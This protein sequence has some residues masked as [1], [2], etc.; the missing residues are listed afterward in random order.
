MPQ[1][2]HTLAPWGRGEMVA[3]IGHERW[4]RQVE[5][6]PAFGPSPMVGGLQQPDGSPLVAIDQVFQGLHRER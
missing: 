4:D 3:N 5:H 6:Q 1:I 2:A